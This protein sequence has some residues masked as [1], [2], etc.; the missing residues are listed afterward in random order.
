MRTMVD[1]I[2]VLSLSD[3][4]D[5][6][7]YDEPVV[8]GIFLKGTEVWGVVRDDEIAAGG[9]D[10]AM[11]DHDSAEEARD[12]FTNKA[13]GLAN[14]L[15]QYQVLADLRESLTGAFTIPTGW[16]AI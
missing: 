1:V 4:E 5:S 11:H 16:D 8:S 9:F 15:V 13:A 6:R 12:C 10:I 3:A 7:M 2:G 14:M